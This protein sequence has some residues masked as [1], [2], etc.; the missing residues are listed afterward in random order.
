MLVCS[1]VQSWVGCITRV[2]VF[3]RG[4]VAKCRR[5]TRA[6]LRGRPLCKNEPFCARSLRLLLTEVAVQPRRPKVEWV[7]QGVPYPLCCPTRDRRGAPGRRYLADIGRF[8]RLLGGFNRRG[9]R[10]WVPPGP[11]VPW[12]G[13]GGSGARQK[14]RKRKF[15]CGVSPDRKRAPRVAKK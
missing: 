12:G 4:I 13:R 8:R 5:V 1:L 9:C 7:A 11:P 6:R 14:P 15:D 3:A 10:G 2:P